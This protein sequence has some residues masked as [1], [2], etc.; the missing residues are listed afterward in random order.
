[1]GNMMVRMGVVIGILAA[2]QLGFLYVGHLT[3]PTVVEPR[4]S[5]EGFPIVVSSPEM[6]TWQ[7]QT[8]KLDDRTFN[9]SE[10]DVAVSRIYSK[11]GR[12][13]KFL[14]AQYN[15][16]S[17]GL[18]HNPMNCYNSQGFTRIGRVQKEPLKA[19]NRPDTAIS[20]STWTRKSEKVIVAY[21]YE[22]GDYTMYERQDLLKTQIA[23]FGKTKWP[24][25][26]KVLLE[27][28]AGESDQAESEI[29]G[30]AQSVREWLGTVQPILD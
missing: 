19:R 16:P 9:E 18:Y 8:A 5:L 7:G 15:Q 3:H 26:F 23:M 10:A 22:V 14:L 17:R 30:M 6:G 2:V 1:M 24:V 11:E 4:G 25:M 20:I 21:W 27:M 13:L 12:I 28:P 29:L